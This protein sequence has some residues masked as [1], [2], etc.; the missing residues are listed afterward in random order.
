MGKPSRSMAADSKAVRVDTTISPYY[1]AILDKRCAAKNISKR[2]ALHQVIEEAQGHLSL[3]ERHKLRET[4]HALRM[5]AMTIAS[6]ARD[7]VQKC[8]AAIESILI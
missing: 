3:G 5:T 8:I 7:E 1:A 2:E 6:P 4:A